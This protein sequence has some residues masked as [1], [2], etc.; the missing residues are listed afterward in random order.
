MAIVDH[1]LRL[2]KPYLRDIYLPGASPSTSPC[3]P[4]EL[5]RP[6]DGLVFAASFVHPA[7]LDSPPAQPEP[8]H[9]TWTSWLCDFLGVRSQIRLL[10]PSGRSLAESFLYVA[11]HRKDKFLGVLEQVWRVEGAALD[12]QPALKQLIG[13]I[14]VPCIPGG[15]RRL[16]ETYLPL[17]SLRSYCGR[18]LGDDE[19]FPFLDLGG[20]TTTE[21]LESK[22]L[23]LSNDLSVSV[24]DDVGFLLDILDLIKETNSQGLSATRCRDVAGLYYDIE[25][26]CQESEY[27]EAVREIIW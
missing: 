5:F 4:E 22:W 24:N 21:E 12:D 25:T 20:P 13:Q 26:K 23:F 3:S 14:S 1:E 11:E 17:D 16:W 7:F 27:P 8:T 6:T 19:P 15:L 10:S 9:P 2:S 18:F